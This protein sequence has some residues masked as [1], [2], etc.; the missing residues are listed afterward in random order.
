MTFYYG[1]SRSITGPLFLTRSEEATPIDGTAKLS[2]SVG[3]IVKGNCH[4][5][6]CGHKISEGEGNTT[7]NTN[8][9]IFLVLLY[10]AYYSQ[11]FLIPVQKQPQNFEWK[12]FCSGT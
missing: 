3:E 2:K 7:L 12:I 9:S 4:I 11:S 5:L 10:Y 6:S 8:T 1:S